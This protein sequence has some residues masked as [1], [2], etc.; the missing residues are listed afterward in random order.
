MSRIHTA[1]LQSDLEA[2]KVAAGKVLAFFRAID[3]STSNEDWKRDRVAEIIRGG[4]VDLKLILER[5][6]D[7]L[8]EE[9]L[10]ERLTLPWEEVDPE[11]ILPSIY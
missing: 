1:L 4:S 2:N 5:Q 9:Y 10:E 8:I 11:T 6:I 7:I 3:W